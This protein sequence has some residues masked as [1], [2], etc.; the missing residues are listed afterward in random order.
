MSSNTTY[1]A[2]RIT[3]ASVA[4]LVGLAAGCTTDDASGDSIL[5]QRS[6]GNSR[7]APLQTSRSGQ[8]RGDQFRGGESGFSGSSR[9]GSVA[10]GTSP[11]GRIQPSDPYAVALTADDPTGFQRTGAAP[12]TGERISLSPK[13]PPQFQPTDAVHDFYGEVFTDAAGLVPLDPDR[14]GGNNLA[15]V[16]FSVEGAD[17][18]PDVAPDGRSVVFASTQHSLTS[19]IFVKPVDSRVV[20]RLTKDEANDVMPKFSPDGDRVAFASNRSGNWDIFVTPST[21][22]AAVQVTTESSHEL[23]PSWSPDGRYLAFSRLGEVSGKWEIWVTDVSN[24]GVTKFLSYGLFPEWSP[25]AGNTANGQGERILFQQS[26][27][28]GDR[29]FTV[30]TLDFTDFNA[31]NLT[32]VASSPYAACINPSWSRDGQWISFATVPNPAQW[33]EMNE[34]RPAMAQLWMVASDGT[35]LVELTDDNAVNLMPTWA[36]DNHI[37]YIS[38]RGGVDNIW[39]LSARTAIIAA[40]GEDPGVGPRFTTVPNNP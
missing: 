24:P 39:S 34:T 37:Y 30:W 27:E 28:R 18:D 20:T 26:K 40:T 16:S 1:H 36:P 8:F 7:I 4:M 32:Q 31:G 23:H 22:G 14:A 3:A 9:G 15:Q 35:S 10:Q 21:G 33:A 25:V 11:Q 5:T 12:R 2:A 19:D 6:N 38:D 29:A 13:T 17:F